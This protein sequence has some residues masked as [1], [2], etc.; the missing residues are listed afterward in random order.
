MKCDKVICVYL[1]KISKI[2]YNNYT[3]SKEILNNKFLKSNK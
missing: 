1:D 3:L 2:L